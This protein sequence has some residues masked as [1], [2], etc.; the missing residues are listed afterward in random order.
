MTVLAPKRCDRSK[1]VAVSR[2]LC[3]DESLA[4]D[5]IAG[6]L[7]RPGRESRFESRSWELITLDQS[8]EKM[9]SS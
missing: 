4:Q 7:A 8:Y 3:L 2:V 5:Q 1:D 9:G 6:G